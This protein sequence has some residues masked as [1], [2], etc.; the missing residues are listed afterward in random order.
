M[1]VVEDTVAIYI[2]TDPAPK[3][4]YIYI[5]TYFIFDPRK[6]LENVQKQASDG[7]R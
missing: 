4:N 6:T 7:G 3:P 1:D 5:H 2:D